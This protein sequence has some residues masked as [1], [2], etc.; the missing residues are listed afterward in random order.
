VADAMVLK[1]LFSGLLEKGAVVIAT[2]NRPPQ[3]LY[4]HGLQRDL[5]LPFIALLQATHAVHDIDSPTDYRLVRRGYGVTANALFIHAATATA[6]AAAAARKGSV[7]GGGG[8]EEEGKEEEDEA[9]YGF[10]E[11]LKHATKGQ[12]L[13]TIALPLPAQGRRLYCPK[14]ALSTRTALFSFQ[15]LCGQALGAAD[16]IAL[17]QAFATVFLADVRACVCVWF[18]FWG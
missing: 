16:Y 10:N 5:F 3:D 8:E 12:G 6:T 18:F 15:E 4:L 7:V 17:A 11:A 13:T 1:R 9:R 2:S 14:V